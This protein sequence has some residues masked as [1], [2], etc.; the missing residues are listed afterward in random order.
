[1]CLDETQLRDVWICTQK[2]ELWSEKLCRIFRFQMFWPLISH[3]QP[4]QTPH[5]KKKLF[6]LG[7][8]V[9]LRLQ[10]PAPLSCFLN[11]FHTRCDRRQFRQ[12]PTQHCKASVHPNVSLLHKW[13]LWNVKW[14]EF[15][16]KFEFDAS[17]VKIYAHPKSTLFQPDHHWVLSAGI[18]L[19]EQ[20]C[21][22]DHIRIAVGKYKDN[23]HRSEAFSL[24]Q[25]CWAWLKIQYCTEV[26]RFSVAIDEHCSHADQWYAPTKASK[27][28]QH[29]ET[30]GRALVNFR[31]VVNTV[32]LVLSRKLWA[33]L[34]CRPVLYPHQGV[35]IEIA[36]WNKTRA[37][38]NLAVLS[39]SCVLSTACR[40]ILVCQ[41]HKHRLYV[42]LLQKVQEKTSRYVYH[43]R[44]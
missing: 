20:W 34:T 43:G 14:G 33:S 11:S 29:C 6:L 21:C 27:L 35:K 38:E 1:M 19:R 31:V 30:R 12:F 17:D 37:G 42:L 23:C 26:C 7:F 3:A 9:R 13:D 15:T 39:Q 24:L 28:K 5:L 32:L 8:E 2:L 22:P 40:Q 41:D 4:L 18:D 44:Y 25:F 10:P 36:L 16:T